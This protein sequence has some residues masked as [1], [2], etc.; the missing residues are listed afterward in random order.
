MSS[1]LWS[2]LTTAEP[3]FWGGFKLIRI[4]DNDAML[5]TMIGFL[6]DSSPFARMDAVGGTSDLVYLTF[7]L[8][9][10]LDTDT[11]LF[12]MIDFPGDSPPFTSMD[13]DWIPSLT[14]L[15]FFG[16]SLIQKLGL[17]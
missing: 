11:K 15:T 10:I 2:L 8:I 12:T 7:G 6:V 17:F 14:N 1:L 4:P 16:I 5:L 3:L 13:D 9:G